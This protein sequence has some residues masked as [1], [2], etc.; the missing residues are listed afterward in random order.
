MQV[1]QGVTRVDRYLARAT[2]TQVALGQGKECNG[3]QPLPW[4][5]ARAMTEKK[6]GTDVSFVST[7]HV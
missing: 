2:T 4:S 5:V 6:K 1:I 3:S 7:L